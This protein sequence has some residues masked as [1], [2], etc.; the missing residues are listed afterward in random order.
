VRWR[1]LR[2]GEEWEWLDVKTNRFDHGGYL[3]RCGAH[4]PAANETGHAQK[5]AETLVRGMEA[6]SSPDEDYAARVSM[7][8][9][10][11]RNTWARGAV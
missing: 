5:A 4:T 3:V 8:S 6:K 10:W 9:M 11:W 1:R 2:L 7:R